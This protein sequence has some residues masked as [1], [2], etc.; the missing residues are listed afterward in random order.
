MSTRPVRVR[1]ESV[2]HPDHHVVII[3]A[4]F[5]GIGAAIELG[6]AGID[7]YVILEKWDGP[8]GTWRA[9]RYPGVAVDIPSFM[10]SFSYEQRSNWSRLFAPGRELL[11]Y[12]EDVMDRHQLRGRTRFGTTVEEMAFDEVADLWRISVD[13]PDGAHQITARYVIS[14]IGALERPVLPDIDG[15]DR[16]RGEIIHTA[17]WDDSI[18]LNGKRVACIGTGAS[19]LQLVP[20]IA[21]RVAHLDVYQR[22]PIWV[23]PKFDPELGVLARTAMSIPPVRSTVRGVA[24]VVGDVAGNVVFQQRLEPLRNA[25][26][27]SIRG[28]MRRQVDDPETREALIPD[29]SFGCKR[30]SMSNTYLRTFNREHVE[31][32]TTPIKNITATGVRTEDGELHKAD[33]L[34]CATGFRIMSEQEPV[35]FPIYG[36]NRTEL[37]Q[38]WLEN[39]FHAYQGV[40]VCGF[41]NLFSVAGPYGFVVGSYFW[42]IESTTKHAVRVIVE[43]DRRGSTTAEIR[44]GPQDRYVKMCR[45]RQASSPLFGPPCATSNT[46]Y[47]NFQGDSPLRPAF[48]AEMWWQ[49][50]HFPLTH[51]RY[52]EHGPGI[53]GDSMVETAGVHN[54]VALSR[55]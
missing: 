49:N 22:T 44:K 25:L 42:M 55:Y 6:R 46:Y 36:R 5:G 19:A 11:A 26:E 29:Y 43:A 35:P 38:F 15:I 1:T 40:S 18:D 9:N 47:V 14:A 50:R 8:G 33:V 28:W 4:G 20:E 32:V 45:Q 52:G 7:D 54:R 17:R 30:P 51:Y 10:Y 13:G 53:E 16:F 12:A 41:P 3:G 39:R 21:D 27:G 37:G 2:G 48:Y 24:T 31:L 23:A 34:I